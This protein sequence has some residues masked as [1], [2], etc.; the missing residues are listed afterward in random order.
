L[1][2]VVKLYD[3]IRKLSGEPR[4]ARFFAEAEAEYAELDRQV[5]EFLRRSANSLNLA[6]RLRALEKKA[7]YEELMQERREAFAHNCREIFVALA[8]FLARAIL[9]SETSESDIVRRLRNTGFAAAEPMNLP[10]FPINSLTVLAAAL[11][12]YLIFAGWI[13][14]HAAG[15]ARQPVDGL[16]MASKITLVRLLTIAVTVWLMQ[17][18]V[19]FR[20]ERGDPLRFFAYAVNG[21]IA[22]VVAFGVSLPFDW[23]NAGRALPPALLSFPLCTALALCCDDWVEDAPPP[24]WLRVA[25]ALGCASVMGITILLLYFGDVLTFGAGKL[26]PGGLGLLVALPSG[27]ALVIGGYVPHIYRAAR[28]AATA[29]RDEASRAAAPE[30]WRPALHAIEAPLAPLSNGHDGGRRAGDAQHEERGEE[31]SQASRQES[32]QII[33]GRAAH[34][35]RAKGRRRTAHLVP[36]KDPGND[37]RRVPAAKELIGQRE[38]G[39]PGGD[40]VEAIERRE[41]RQADDVKLRERHDDQ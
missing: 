24:K 3:R 33:P 40:P 34:G 12:L 11:F 15:T 4:Y 7:A 26:T 2:R 36:G 5:T 29:R 13:F 6:E 25:E 37:D 14:S 1:T 35:A 9:R 22:A 19:F 30:A 23:A 28:R 31:A 38:G 10:Q 27:L 20:R 17:R 39:R 8:R 18:Y 41:N 21:F 16:T 32:Q